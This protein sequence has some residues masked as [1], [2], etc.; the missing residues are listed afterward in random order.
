MRL[1]NALFSSLGPAVL[2]AS[3]LVL[4]S[5]GGGGGSTPNQ[6]NPPGGGQQIGSGGTITGRVV[7]PEGPALGGPFVQVIVRNSSNVV[8][9]P[10]INPQQFGP[11]AGR[12]T[13]AG[14]PLG[15]DLTVSIDYVSEG[16][17]DFLGADQTVRLSGG[18]SLD[19]GNI[20]LTNEYMELGWSAYKAKNFPLAIS[21]F[22]TSKT[23]RRLS[24]NTESSSYWN[25]FGWV[26]VKRGR[27]SLPMCSVVNAQGF[28]WDEALT[29]FNQAS[30]TDSSDA[31]SRVGAA[32]AYLA[33]NAK[34]E[35]LDPAQFNLKQFF[36]RLRNPFF[37]EAETK[38]N[39]AL[40]IA[41]N[42]SSD[43]EEVIAGDLEVA[44]LFTQFMQGKSVTLQ[45][46]DEM[47][48]REDLNQGS[49]ET[50]QAL[51]DLVAY[52]TAPQTGGG[53]FP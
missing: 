29:L 45:Q 50:L 32:A 17:G 39:E 40:A 53:Q 21:R 2:L 30:A 46:I 8:I 47:N 6:P 34:T 15:T 51:A 43:H 5:C 14:M 44:R 48:Q 28:E 9:S 24:A 41:P 52:K 1:T 10:T 42:Y 35:L 13:V 31:D 3:A 49:L 36:Y 19:L 4:A 25:A 26:Y 16:K 27:D 18:G 11:D 37:D 22:D 33:L 20:T 12:F 38:L 7:S 23:A